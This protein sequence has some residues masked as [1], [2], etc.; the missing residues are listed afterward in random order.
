MRINPARKKKQET[1]TNK[2]KRNASVLELYEK[3]QTALKKT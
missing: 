2:E 3:I 1:R